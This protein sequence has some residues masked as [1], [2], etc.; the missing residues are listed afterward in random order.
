MYIRIY[1]Y[2]YIY[3]HVYPFYTSLVLI[4]YLFS[5]I[6]FHF[7]EINKFDTNIVSDFSKG[8]ALPRWNFLFYVNCK[9][10]R[11]WSIAGPNVT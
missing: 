8:D 10:T 5:S 11:S 9:T 2:V 4:I 3:I 1:M 7:L 6:L